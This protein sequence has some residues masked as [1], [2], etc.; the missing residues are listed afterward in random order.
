MT[1]IECLF[2]IPL[3]QV[4]TYSAITLISLV[5]VIIY[6]FGK[7]ITNKISEK[8]YNPDSKCCA[9]F[10]EDNYCPKCGGEY[11]QIGKYFTPEGYK[12]LMDGCKKCGYTRE[13]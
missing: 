1:I 8:I 2:L 12:V 6:Y 11:Q 7:H 9:T 5:G 10:I 4:L 13:R 3:M